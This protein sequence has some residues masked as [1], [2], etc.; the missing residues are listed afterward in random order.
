MA[1]AVISG[2]SMKAFGTL[3]RVRTAAPPPVAAV[4]TANQ[5]GSKAE[6]AGA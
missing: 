2:P 1:A 4:S 3:R 5:A 6:A